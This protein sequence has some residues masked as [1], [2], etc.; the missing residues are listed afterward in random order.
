MHVR[1]RRFT[2]PVEESE[3]QGRPPRIKLIDLGMAAVYDPK[4][5]NAKNA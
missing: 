1:A 2:L 4:K 5:V 3:A